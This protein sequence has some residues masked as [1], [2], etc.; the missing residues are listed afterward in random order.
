MIRKSLWV[1]ASWMT[2]LCSSPPQA[3]AWGP[4]GHRMTAETAALLLKDKMPEGW[5]PLIARHRFEI[6]YYSMVP[7][8]VFKHKDPQK[9]KVEGPTHFFDTDYLPESLAW[10]E[11]LPEAYPD[12]KKYLSSKIAP[13]KL[14]TMGS[15]PWR[16]QQFLQ[17]AQSELKEVKSLE[18]FY[19]T[20]AQSKGQALHIFKGLYFLGVMSHY[21][22]DGA[23]PHHA[24][25]DWNGYSLGQGGVHF[26]FESDCVNELEPGLSEAVLKEARKN[27]EQW[28]KNWK[29]DFQTSSVRLMLRFYHESSQSLRTA[30]KIDREA[31]ITQLA[32]PGSKDFAQ[33]RAAADACGAFKELLIQQLAKGSVMTAYLW[34]KTLPP[35][36]NPKAAT[37]LQFSDLDYSPQFVFP[38]YLRP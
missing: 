32:Q 8:A 34:E 28:L 25:S 12:F 11:E 22:G 27:R 29:A 17:L 26:Y 1:L 33:R 10:A 7:D 15:A 5:G 20:G 18:G 4:L 6:G 16:T 13:Q 37:S 19:Q 31:A 30:N 9:G 35:L 14:S 2:L 36:T 23:V 21:S 3:I 24:T 38:D